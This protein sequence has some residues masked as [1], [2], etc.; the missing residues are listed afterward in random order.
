MLDSK[1]ILLVED[2]GVDVMAVQRVLK[3]LKAANELAYAGNGEEALAY[4]R[5]PENE[6]PCMILLD[7]NMP[8]MGGLEFLQVLRAN[9]ALRNIPVMVVSTSAE[10]QDM[11]RSFELGA[12]AYIVK[13]YS[14]GEFRERMRAITPYLA[15]VGPTEKLEPAPV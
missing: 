15:V 2:D 8:K 1:P 11:A 3:E 10:K 14:Y 4:L 12:V 7:L 9:E 6:A 13:C 5:S